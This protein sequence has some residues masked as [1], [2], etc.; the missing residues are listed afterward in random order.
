VHDNVNTQAQWRV[1]SYY[2]RDGRCHCGKLTT[3]PH[4]IAPIDCASDKGH[5]FRY[6]LCTI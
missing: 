1:F 2:S 4:T 3:V 5:T 6:N